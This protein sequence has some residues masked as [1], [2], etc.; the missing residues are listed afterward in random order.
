MSRMSDQKSAAFWTLKILRI[1]A[2]F[3]LVLCAGPFL[4]QGGLSRYAYEGLTPHP[5][6]K[7][8]AVGLTMA[9]AGI[10]LLRRLPWRS[11]GPQRP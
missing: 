1:A 5:D 8:L 11:R 10:M 3:L 2:G 7:M 9:L 6:R 4:I